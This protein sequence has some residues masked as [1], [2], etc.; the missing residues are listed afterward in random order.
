MDELTKLRKQI[1]EIDQELVKTIAQRFE[2][3]EKIGKYKAA[4]GIEPLAPKRWK[5]VMDGKRKLAKEYDLPVEMIEKI[6]N[7]MHKFA[8]DIEN[9]I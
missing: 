4:N 6:Y 1:D 8:L 7:T 9:E 5:Q 3:V 2:I